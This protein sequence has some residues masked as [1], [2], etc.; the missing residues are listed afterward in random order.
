VFVSHRQADVALAKQIASE[1]S[2]QGFEYWLDV[3]DPNLGAAAALPPPAQAYT[4][5]S[6]RSCSASRT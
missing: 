6:A 4:S 3:F 1:I 2:R 5:S